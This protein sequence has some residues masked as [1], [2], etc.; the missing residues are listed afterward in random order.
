MTWLASQI[1][2]ARQ[3]ALAFLI[4]ILG[5]GLTFASEQFLTFGNLRALAL[6]TAIDAVLVIGQ[7]FVII[8]AGFDLSIGATLALSAVSVGLLAQAGAPW[9]LAGSAGLA[10]GA[11][12]GAVN[13]FL[14]ARVKVN[15]LIT[16]LGTLFVFRGVAL[17]ISS[18][19]TVSAG[20]S[21]LVDF[22]GQGLVFSI[23]VPVFISAG[24]VA[25]SWVL[26][27]WFRF[28]RQIF[29]VGSNPEA[30][31]LSGIHVD[32]VV[33]TSYV[34]M[35]VLAGLAGILTIARLSN[36]DANVGTGRELEVITAAILGGA[37][38]RGGEG[39]IVGSVLALFLLALVT[40]ALILLNIPVFWQQLTVGVVL[41]LAVVVNLWRLRIRDQLAIRSAYETRPAN[42]EGGLQ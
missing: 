37:S 2:E 4:L 20:Q 41:I 6:G 36:A 39:S 16:T 31:R 21:P 29:Y 5:I 11:V 19:L 9:Y 30:A 33:F 17:V 12:A 8:G 32:R 10:A 14:I 3:A 40:N 24:V 34:V 1:F 26:L 28:P 38:L 7:T 22:V 23:P 25:L 35:G 42:K 27:R 15:P 18:G 13:G